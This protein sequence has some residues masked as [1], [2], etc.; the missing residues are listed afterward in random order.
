MEESNA[1]LYVSQNKENSFILQRSLSVV[2]RHR[3]RAKDARR[4]DSGQL[5]RI[6]HRDRIRV[7]AS[8]DDDLLLRMVSIWPN[9][10]HA[11]YIYV[12]SNTPKAHTSQIIYLLI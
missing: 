10:L 6:T 12:M 1:L 5:R 2:I 4:T 3:L 8:L 7:A 9:E 11:T